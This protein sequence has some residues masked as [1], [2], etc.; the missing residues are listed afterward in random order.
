MKHVGLRGDAKDIASQEQLGG[1]GSATT[2]ESEINATSDLNSVVVTGQ[3]GI[4]ATTKV[5]AWIAGSTADHDEEAHLLAKSLCDVAVT[6]L[7]AGT[8]FTLNLINPD[9]TVRGL[10]KIYWSY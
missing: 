5:Q 7:V 6:S 8:G 2:G 10:I 4:T 1:G 3:T 9:A